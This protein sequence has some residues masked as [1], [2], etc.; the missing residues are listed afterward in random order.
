MGADRRPGRLGCQFPGKP[1]R[2]HQDGVEPHAE[3]FRYRAL[4][5]ARFA[6]DSDYL[7]NAARCGQ[8]GRSR[9]FS[10]CL[11]TCWSESTDTI[12]PTTCKAPSARWKENCDRVQFQL[13]RKGPKR[14]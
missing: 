10:A 14:H 8:V 1:R 7:G 9:I 5:A 6:Q 2:Q 13:G 12:I 3:A 11:S 4:Y